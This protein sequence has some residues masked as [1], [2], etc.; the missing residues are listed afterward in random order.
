MSRVRPELRLLHIFKT[1]PTWQGRSV[2]AMTQ[3]A[4]EAWD[5]PLQELLNRG[6]ITGFAL[7]SRFG[8]CETKAGMLADVFQDSA[9]MKQFSGL[10]HSAEAPPAFDLAGLHCVVF[11]RTDCDM[12][13]VSRN[14]T[15]GLAVSALPFG[16]LVSTYAR[17]V[18]PQMAVPALL[19]IVDRLRT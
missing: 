13:A 11:Q 4:A 1:H 19:G 15:L 9:C 8:C 5:A 10:F 6:V 14:R 18:F 2:G 17:P 12:L 16:V 7:I 3:H